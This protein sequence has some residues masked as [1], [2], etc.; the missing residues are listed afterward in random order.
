MILSETAPFLAG[1]RR[2]VNAMETLELSEEIRERI[3]EA[4]SLVAFSGAG[5]SRESGLDTFRGAGGLWETMRPE[6]MATPQS[7]R[8]DPAKVWRRYA[9]RFR[10]A[11][12]AAPNPAH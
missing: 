2:S 4:Q 12:E 1:A 8:A 5:V 7:F 9:W 11:T 3:R 10:Q 6:E